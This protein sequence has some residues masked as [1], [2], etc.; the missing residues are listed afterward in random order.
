MSASSADWRRIFEGL[1]LVAGRIAAESRLAGRLASAANAAASSTQ[2]AARTAAKNASSPSSSP[3]SADAAAAAASAVLREAQQRLADA[4]SAT[5]RFQPQEIAEAAANAVMSVA[6]TTSASENSSSTTTTEPKTRLRAPSSAPVPLAAA[7]PPGRC[8]TFAPGGTG[9][10]SGIAS[11]PYYALSTPPPARP[12]FESPLD[13]AFAVGGGGRGEQ[14][15]RS[16]RSSPPSRSSERR[17]P[18]SA[19]ARAF[20]FARLGASMVAGVIVDRVS[21]TIRGEE[22]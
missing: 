10:M 22:G 21:A 11:S 20:G 14:G 15:R 3:P 6:A 16:S 4:W 13:E 8:L 12:T 18:S 7:A 19:A 2:G 17:V 5:E 9:A 1:S